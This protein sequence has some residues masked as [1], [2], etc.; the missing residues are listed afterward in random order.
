MRSGLAPSKASRSPCGT[1]SWVCTVAATS[2]RCECCLGAPC[3]TLH[4]WLGR[5]TSAEAASARH[6]EPGTPVASTHRLP[7]VRQGRC[8]VRI[9]VRARGSELA[10]L[11]RADGDVACTRVCLCLLWV[12]TWL[13]YEID[14]CPVLT[15]LSACTFKSAWAF[16]ACVDWGDLHRNVRPLPPP[17]PSHTQQ[18]H[19]VTQPMPHG[20]HLATTLAPCQALCKTLGYFDQHVR[21][22]T[23]GRYGMVAPI[24][25]GVTPD[26]VRCKASGGQTS[27]IARM[28]LRG[29]LK[30]NVDKAAQVSAARPTLRRV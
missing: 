16:N 7:G 2:L 29:G 10:C 4:R 14:R 15:A 5:G 26:G 19:A 21:T 1:S 11:R 30:L 12:G 8:Q 18:A 27:T 22:G 24:K 6:G 28:N 3:V 13:R 9:R 23:A 20:V 25:Q 17:P